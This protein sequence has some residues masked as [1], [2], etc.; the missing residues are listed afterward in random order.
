[1]RFLISI[2]V[3]VLTAHAADFTTYVGP[4]PQ[5][6][7]QVYPFSVGALATDSAGDTYVT[8]N[9][10]FISKL[11]PAGNIVF[12]KAFGPVNSY[13]YGF[14]IA[15]DPSGNIWVGGQTS[16]TISPLVNALQ[17]S[18]AFSG[19][20][21]IIKM[22]PDGTVLYSSYFGGVQGASS[23]NGIAADQDGNVYVTGWTNSSDYP[24]TPGLPASPVDPTVP[25]YGMF[26]AKLDSSGQKILYS[27]VITGSQNCAPDCFANTPKTLGLGIA[28]D[29]SGEALVAGT[30][31]T[32][33][34]AIPDANV[35]PGTFVFK[36]N[37]AGNGL[38]Y[39][40]SVNDS[41][42]FGARPIAADASGNAYLTGY[43]Y[44]PDF[45]ATPGAYQTTYD[46]G[47]NP[48]AFAMK[49][50]PS[51][52]TVWATLLGGQASPNMAASA[53]SLDGSGNV[54]LTGANTQNSDFVAEL[55]T[56]GSA[57]PY[58]AQFPLA[59]S[60]HAV[61]LTAEAGQD[62]AV[63]PS[64]VVHF[65]GWLGL[66]ST[67]SPVQPLAARALS[68]VNAASNQLLGTITPGEIVSIY[69]AGMGPTTPVGATPVNGAFPTSL[70]G[71][72]VL[73]DG[74]PIPLLYVSDSQINAEIPSPLNGLENGLADLRVVNNA[75]ALP[76]FRLG[77]TT[78]VFSAFYSSGAYLAVTN[79][80]GTVNS[81]TNPAKAGSYI[82]LWATGFGSVPGVVLDGALA[83][84]ANNYCSTCLV[85]FS[86]FSFHVTESVQYAGP[87]PGLID[88]LMQINAMI[89]TAQ[90]PTSQL[91]VSFAAPGAVFP[92]LLG[93]VWVS[94]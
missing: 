20:G 42:T 91:Q 33:L 4:V 60:I 63:D 68:I 15:L 51:G 90:S 77:V 92:Q 81:K 94:Q 12:T 1:M 17:S 47:N 22:A 5:N 3:F 66:V 11:D 19:T 37:A 80:D 23:V 6:P 79:Q 16:A 84:S 24:I 7:Y 28:V 62:I 67:I 75:V 53:I 44:G 50:S 35:G 46:A 74:T 87:S 41:I 39:F 32:A 82:S 83:A 48:E 18:P 64:G 69:G 13:S 8:G 36:I 2:A 52:T 31:N 65:A 73:V 72:Q 21:F 57:L 49:L 78:S 58:I 85:T 10:V 43:T 34:P 26:A 29:G 56:D 89:P 30:S 27:T 86:S 61:I 70:S 76:H 93:F 71:V 14:S 45:P 54:W 38:V 88:G 9:G 59:K 40:A 25:S 55:S